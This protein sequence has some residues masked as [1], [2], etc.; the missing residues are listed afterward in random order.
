MA[1]SYSV[2]AN[3]VRFCTHVNLTLALNDAAFHVPFS[4]TFDFSGNG[5]IPIPTC[6]RRKVHASCA[7]FTH[8]NVTS[9]SRGIDEELVDSD[10]F[11]LTICTCLDRIIYGLGRIL[12]IDQDL[13]IYDYYIIYP[14]WLSSIR[15]L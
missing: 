13:V 2:S 12:M 7:I 9:S 5:Q 11:D 4:L 3:G 10:S 1:A 14:A 8:Y 6:P 15:L